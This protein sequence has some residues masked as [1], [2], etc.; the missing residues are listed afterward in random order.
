MLFTVAKPSMSRLLA[1]LYF[2]L[3]LVSPDSVVLSA[4]QSVFDETSKLTEPR[5]N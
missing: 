3:V 2:L 4:G 1:F 5:I